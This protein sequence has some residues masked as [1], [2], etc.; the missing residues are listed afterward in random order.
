MHKLLTLMLV[1]VVAML[2]NA[3]AIKCYACQGYNSNYQDDYHLNNKYC[4]LNNFNS[5]RVDTL[6]AKECMTLV[7]YVPEGTFT[8]RAPSVMMQ[9][10]MNQTF[11]QMKKKTE[12]EDIH[13]LH[14]NGYFCNQDRCNDRRPSNAAPV[15]RALCLPLLLLPLVTA[16]HRLLA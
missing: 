6:T 5:D 12:V 11:S 13:Y 1:A 14:F 7:Q 16:S 9:K 8:F 4:S 15:I 3:G 10:Q 2:P